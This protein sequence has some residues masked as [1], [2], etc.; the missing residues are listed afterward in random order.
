V[1]AENGALLHRPATHEETPLGDAPPAAFARTL[2]QRGV[3]PLSAGRVIV[4]TC[5][6]HEK[7]VLEVIRDLGL[8]LHVIFNKGSVMVLP[9]GV[10]KATGLATALG[11]MRL[12]P[13]NVVGVGD[14]ENNHAFLRFSECSAAVANALPAVRREANL[15]TA[16]SD[17]AGVVELIDE[18]LAD[19]L[20]GRVGR[21]C[22]SGPAPRTPSTGGTGG[23]IPRAGCPLSG[24]C[25]SKAPTASST[26][27]PR[28][29]NCSRS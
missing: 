12:S 8:E 28:T 2:R 21:R 19:D 27:A 4:A 9:A 10:N 6:P 20:R 11:Q 14:A 18:L 16:G 7:T 25:T 13:H 26:S 1:V 3:T 22:R 29:P 5:E 23:S 15:V 24:A 17:G